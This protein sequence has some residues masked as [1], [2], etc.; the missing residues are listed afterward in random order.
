MRATPVWVRS[1]GDRTGCPKASTATDKNDVGEPNSLKRGQR[2]RPLG[3][4]PLVEAREGEKVRNLQQHPHGSSGP[5]ARSQ[6]SA[7]CSWNGSVAVWTCAVTT[8]RRRPKPG[9]CSCW[10]GGRSCSKGAF[11]EW[12]YRQPLRAP[13]RNYTKVMRTVSRG[14]GKKNQSQFCSPS[15]RGHFGPVARHHRRFT[16]FMEPRIVPVIHSSSFDEAW[17]APGWPIAACATADS[18]RPKAPTL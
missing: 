6:T 15:R 13:H 4:G 16:R 12:G 18:A 10:S 2:K 5:G 1:G 14:L 11:C 17:R 3:E 8:R 7:C 9:L